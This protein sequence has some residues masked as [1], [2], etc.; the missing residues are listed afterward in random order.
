MP[1]GKSA[2]VVPLAVGDVVGDAGRPGPARA[3]RRP[4]ARAR[5]AGGR[6]RAGAH[7]LRDARRARRRRRDREVAA[8]RGAARPHGGDDRVLRGACE[9]YEAG[10]PYFAFRELLRGG[11]RRPARRLAGHRREARSAAASPTSRPSS[12]PWIP[13]LA[14]PLDVTVASTREVDELQ[15]AFR[16]A[17]LHGAVETL[18]AAAAARDLRRS[19]SRTSTGWTRPRPSSSATSRGTSRRTPGSSARRGGPSPGGFSAAEG[20]PPVPA[21]TM[22]LE[23]LAPDDAKALV[24]AAGADVADEEAD[25]IAARAGGNPLFLQELVAARTAG[26][27]ARGGRAAGDGRGRGDEPHRPAERRRPRAPPLGL[28]ARPGV[29]RR[30]RRRRRRGRGCGGRL[31]R[32]EPAGRV[33][34]A[35]P[36]RPGGLPLPA[37]AHPR[38]GVR[39]PVLPSA[40][41][42]PRA[43]G[44]RV[45][46]PGRRAARGPL[47]PL[48][49]RRALG[50]RL[51]DL[52]RGGRA[53]AGEVR[54]HRGGRVLR[55]CAG[56]GAP[57]PRRPGGGARPGVGGARRRLRARGPLRRGDRG[58]PERAAGRDV[59][60]PA[61]EGGDDPRAGRRLRGRAAL[62]PPRSQRGGAGGR[63]RARGRH[64][65]RL[66]RRRATA[67]G[68]SRTRSGGPWT[69]SSSRHEIGYLPG[70]AHGYFLLHIA[71]TATGHPDRAAFRGLA[72]P[73]YEELGD[74]LGQAH[75]LNNLGIEA[76][77][78]GRWDEA[79]D[80]YERSKAGAVADRRRRQRRARR[81][82]HRRDPQRPGQARRGDVRCSR[83]PARS[84]PA[85]AGSSPSPSR[86]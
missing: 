40:R 37:R 9:Q 81:E 35:R 12:L 24:R 11:D 2:E 31:R 67:R 75:V 76:Y 29:P 80:L 6:A 72:L 56:G 55:P 20:T 5:A 33:R 84:R 53:C 27:T 47:A 30:A 1:K 17:R 14:I 25:A 85:P 83:R 44:R 22:R 79:L 10:T 48:L 70:L 51:A 8:A 28:G 73:I 32:V 74:L 63:A 66:R 18:L 43:R 57:A 77:Y 16:R 41:R 69:P 49:L 64:A 23:P 39:G 15:P 42:A 59:A 58:L 82:Q 78:D 54:E 3:A 21:V 60:A 46:A 71:H 7:G 61:A 19:S 26:S 50:R 38:R 68:T 45:R 52:D 65:R 62:V 13:L 86:R 36:G 4:D 34:R